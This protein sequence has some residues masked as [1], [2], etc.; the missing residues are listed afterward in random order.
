MP[1]FVETALNR[2]LDPEGHLV[3]ISTPERI[4]FGEAQN[5]PPNAQVLDS[6]YVCRQ[7]HRVGT[8]DAAELVG[9]LELARE[10]SKRKIY[11]PAMSMVP[12]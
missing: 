11:L 2:A 9:W 4:T 3:Y 1:A 8:P 12:A 10:H 7:K 6:T 5:R